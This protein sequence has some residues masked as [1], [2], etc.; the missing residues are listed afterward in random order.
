VRKD[1]AVLAERSTTWLILD[2]PVELLRIS[3]LELHDVIR[4]QSSRRAIVRGSMRKARSS[5]AKSSQAPPAS[6]AD[7]VMLS[8]NGVMWK[9]SLRR[10]PGL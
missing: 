3:S 6:D 4:D 9:T 5:L 1:H 7:E 2:N 8:G 10:I